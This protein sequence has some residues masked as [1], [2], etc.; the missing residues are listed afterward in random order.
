MSAD[1]AIFVLELNDAYVIKESTMSMIDDLFYNEELSIQE[2]TMVPKGI[3]SVFSNHNRRSTL[4][5]ALDKAQHLL[6]LTETE[7]GIH[8]IKAKEF[9]YSEVFVNR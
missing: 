7:Y 2:S 8:I 9:N 1:N 5:S 3:A 6:R 4:E